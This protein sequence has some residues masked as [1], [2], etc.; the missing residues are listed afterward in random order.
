MGR[1]LQAGRAK[2]GDETVQ[3][4]VKEAKQ[5]E[6]ERQSRAQTN[7]A[8]GAALGGGARWQKFHARGKS[9]QH[10]IRMTK[11]DRKGRERKRSMLLGIVMIASTSGNNLRLCWQQWGVVCNHGIAV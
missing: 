6:L 10:V 3:R 5:E 1:W 7:Q 9:G 11:E 4:K 8:L 2:H